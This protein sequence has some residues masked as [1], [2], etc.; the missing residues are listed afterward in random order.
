M[1]Y[2]VSILSLLLFAFLS[3]V[4]AWDALVCNYSK[5]DVSV[6]F[7]VAASKPFTLSVPKE[8]NSPNRS[9]GG[10]C[11]AGTSAYIS[12][13]SPTERISLNVS[14]IFAQACSNWVVMIFDAPKNNKVVGWTILSTPGI[15]AS[16]TCLQP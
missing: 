14:G 1:K 4:Y 16:Q 13:T 15:S 2:S 6:Q 7:D 3:E 9:V 12:N 11:F 5:K 8:S 10:L